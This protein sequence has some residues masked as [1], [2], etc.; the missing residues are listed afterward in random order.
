MDLARY[1]EELLEA[2]PGMEI[3][4]PAVLSIVC[5]R[6]LPRDRAGAVVTDEGLIERVNDEI[7]RRVWE[8]GLAMITSTRVRGR[9]VLRLCIVNHNT[10]RS[11]VESVV[12]LLQELGPA[13]ARDVAGA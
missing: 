2:T 6:Y 10:L 8:S 7:R 3:A 12:E 13:A 5:F 11:D 4:S 9:F 1:A